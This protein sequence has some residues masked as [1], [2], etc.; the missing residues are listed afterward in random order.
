ML[1]YL[2]IVQKCFPFLKARI[3]RFLMTF[4]NLRKIKVYEFFYE[5]K[6]IL[7][8]NPQVSKFFRT[9]SKM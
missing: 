1:N 5:R 7:T 6:F 2:K 3:G 8:Y 4:H 9:G